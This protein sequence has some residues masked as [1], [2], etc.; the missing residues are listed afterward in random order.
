M[1]NNYE[2]DDFG[3][4]HQI[5][6]EK[7]VYDENYIKNGYCSNEM[8]LA[9]KNMANLRL[10]YMIGV[11]KNS[12]NSVLDVGYGNGEF[13]LSAQKYLNVCSGYDIVRGDFLP[14]GVI[15]EKSIT[16][17]YY[18]VITFFDSLEHF[19]DIDFVKDLKCRYVIISVPWC[20]YFSDSWFEKWKHRKP[21]EHLHHFNEKSL[22]LFME[23][24][25]FEYVNHCNVED[26]IRETSESYSNIL[27]AC[28]EK[29]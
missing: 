1:L 28:F 21:N 22:K 2:T 20:H 7:F 23:N 9:T 15:E 4:I 24:F 8:K 27:T 10:G 14:K 11:T 6:K 26:S 3:V 19:D 16:E 13:L 29:K 17:N 12:V 25:N 18:D 5:T